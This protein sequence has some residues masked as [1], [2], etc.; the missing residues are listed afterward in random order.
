GGRAS[1]HTGWD[2]VPPFDGSAWE[3]VEAARAP[4]RPGADAILE[5]LDG[6]VPLVGDRAGGSDP[7]TTVALA[8]LGGRRFV[9]VAQDHGPVEPAGYRTAQRG[10]ALAER[11]GIPLVTLI[12]THGAAV[13][14]AADDA[15]QAGEIART[16]RCLL[17]LA[18][19]TLGV[20]VGE[21]GS[22][23]AIALAAVDLLAVQRTATFS[24][25]A[26]EGAAAILHRDPDR[27]AEVADRLGLR[28][29]DLVRLGIAD[30]VVDDDP[31]GT[32]AV[33]D[34]WLADPGRAD[35]PGRRARW[36]RVADGD[37]PPHADRPAPQ[38]PPP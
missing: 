30:L 14:A 31:G 29:A 24:V 5:G 18:V 34:R 36:R 27:A 22:G 16:L 6:L 20:V 25:I 11:L 23:G 32:L 4:A 13:G 10:M 7:H 26:P 2:D 28:S 17:G 37:E 19:P 3:A 35:P 33:I 1:R 8:R 15:G 38:I 9:V 21:G 12:D